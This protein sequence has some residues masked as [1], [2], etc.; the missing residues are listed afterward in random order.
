MRRPYSILLPSY[1]YRGGLETPKTWCLR[2]H[3]YKEIDLLLI[4]T[5][6]F[7]EDLKTPELRGRV[8][9]CRDV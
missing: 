5:N 8:W 9:G 2:A 7:S 3:L 4:T 6:S 1:L